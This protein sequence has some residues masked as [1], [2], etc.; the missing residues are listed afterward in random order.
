[1]SEGR[2]PDTLAALRG[3]AGDALVDVHVDIDHHRS[4]FTLIAPAGPIV[5]A[6]VALARVAVAR[7]DLR[8]HVGVHP[9]LGAI[10]VVPFVA[11]AD[12]DGAVAL[13]ARE[14]A[15]A[16]IAA[17]SVPCFRY[18]LLPDGTTRSLPT[19]RR[20][21]FVDLAPDAGPPSA[22]VSAGA[23]SLGV[24]APLVAWNLWLQGAT[25]AQTRELATA[26]R[27]DAVRALGF[28]VHGA[29]QVSCNLVD[30]ARVSPLDVYGIV[31]ARLPRGARIVR[32]ELVG[33]IGSELLD[34]IPE[35]WWARLDLDPARTVEAAAARVGIEV[36][37]G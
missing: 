21:A 14:R 8:D 3:A 9:R 20:R 6:V 28:T 22:H 23:T 11:V 30:T 18:G 24:R 31:D 26:V 33:L 13:D 19:V 1:M 29:T 10:D 4:V 34:R 37:L 5:D 35:A 2:D 25:L 27:S 36:G 12:T 32:C 16:G 7:I 17:L 15:L